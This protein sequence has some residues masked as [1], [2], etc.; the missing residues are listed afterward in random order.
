MF[1]HLTQREVE[2]SDNTLLSDILL[3]LPCNALHAFRSRWRDPG[4]GGGRRGRE[5]DTFLRAREEVAEPADIHSR[6]GIVGR[7][8]TY[9][10]IENSGSCSL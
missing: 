3:Q 10:A 2:L 7:K 9:G 8:N 6:R 5:G 4:R 1:F